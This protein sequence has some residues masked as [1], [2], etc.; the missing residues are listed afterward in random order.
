MWMTIARKMDREFGKI[1]K[2]IDEV[3]DR[4]EEMNKKAIKTRKYPRWMKRMREKNGKR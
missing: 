1:D 2:E 4:S 3:G